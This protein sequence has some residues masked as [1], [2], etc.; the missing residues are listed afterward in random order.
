MDAERTDSDVPFA[1]SFPDYSLGQLDSQAGLTT[2]SETNL[3]PFYE[4]PPFQVSSRP[5]FY[6]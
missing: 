1:E 4:L 3:N 2:D 5:K 6:A